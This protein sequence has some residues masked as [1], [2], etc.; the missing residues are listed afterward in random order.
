M[1]S[2]LYALFLFQLTAEDAEFIKD[3]SAPY[4]PVGRGKTTFDL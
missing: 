2:N 1:E 4:Y 3:Y